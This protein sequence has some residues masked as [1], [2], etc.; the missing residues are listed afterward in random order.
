MSSSCRMLS[1]F[2]YAIQLIHL[3]LSQSHI[4]TDFITF[5]IILFLNLF[6]S[7]ILDILTRHNWLL[8]G[9]V[10]AAKLGQ[11]CLPHIAWSFVGPGP[12]YMVS[13][14]GEV[15]DPTQRGE[16]VTCRGLH[17]LSLEKGNSLNHSGLCY[18]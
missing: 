4:S 8:G 6:T 7:V 5:S 3:I 12:F 10:T 14:P 2:F 18:L 9:W 1:S 16:C 15:T 11:V 17:I 13:M